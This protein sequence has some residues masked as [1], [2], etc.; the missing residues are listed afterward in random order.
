[1]AEIFP[2]IE[3]ISADISRARTASRIPLLEGVSWRIGEGQF[4]ALGAAPGR[5]KTDLLCTAAALQRPLKGHH[6]IRGKDT[7]EMDEHELVVSHRKVAMIFD[8]GRLFPNLSVADNLM[9]PLAY[10][11]GGS[12]RELGTRVSEVLQ[13]TGLESVRDRHPT[14]ITRNLHQRVG[15][16]RALVLDPE[17][18]IIDNPLLAIDPRQGRWWLDFLCQLNRGHAVCGKRPLTIVVGADDLRPWTDMAT[19]FAVLKDRTLQVIG[20][21]E[22]LRTTREAVVQELL[23]P[24]FETN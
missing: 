9:L 7:R 20:G 10:H 11:Q 21:R 15:L 2:I 6:L 19:D 3:F 22:D 17:V 13:A 1:V 23:T 18:L 16:A 8:T 14:E 4:W 5:G 12:R 24:A